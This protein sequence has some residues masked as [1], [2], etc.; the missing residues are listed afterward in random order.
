DGMFLGEVA[1]LYR[2]NTQIPPFEDQLRLAQIPYTV[3]GGQKFYDKK[4]IKDLIAYLSVIYNHR[5][6]LSLRRVLN[7]P[8]RGIGTQSLRRFLE[9]STST[10][11]PLFNVLEEVARSDDSKASAIKSFMDVIYKYRSHFATMKLSD[12]LSSLINDIE[13]MQ[14]IEKSYDSPKHVARK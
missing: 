1:I 7:V 14:F 10:N 11:T 2:S 6:E 12:A 8:Q 9:I 13:Y 3:I 4:E 5:D